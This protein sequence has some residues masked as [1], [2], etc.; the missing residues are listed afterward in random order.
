M[1]IRVQDERKQPFHIVDKL[2]TWFWL[3]FIGHTGY[4]LYNLYISLINYNTKAAFPSIRRVAEFLDVSE[5]TVRKYNRILREYGLIRIEERINPENGGQVSH[6]YFILDPPP[7]PEHL[8]EEYRRRRLVHSKLMDLKVLASQVE[9]LDADAQALAASAETSAETPPVQPLQGGLQ[10]LQ[11]GVQA[12]NPGVQPMNQTPAIT[13]GGPLRKVKKKRENIDNNS[14]PGEAVVVEG[15]LAGLKETL[16]EFGVHA[17]MADKLVRTYDP[18]QIAAA[19]ETLLYLIHQ[20][21]GP[22]DNAAWLVAA[23][24]QG[25]ELSATR[26]KKEEQATELAQLMHLEHRMEEDKEQAREQFAARRQA[27]LQELGVSAEAQRVWAEVVAE[28]RRRGAWSPVYELLFLEKLEGN[29]AT[30]RVEATVARQVLEKPERFEALR[31]A[32]RRVTKRTIY[33]TLNG[34]TG[35]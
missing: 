18:A 7:L 19:C 27:R 11:E 8:Q 31:R 4:T 5:N 21:H 22:R 2:V 29:A 33:V 13:A 6:L 24:T 28:L 14:T 1:L 35:S 34:E 16:Q 17:K 20:G 25:Y 26:R 23:I 32:L 3:P 10:P 15:N 12:L 9:Q 30:I